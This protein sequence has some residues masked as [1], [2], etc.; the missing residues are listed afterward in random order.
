MNIRDLPRGCA[1]PLNTT[2][3]IKVTS[4]VPKND[5]GLNERGNSSGRPRIDDL[6]DS[7]F[8]SEAQISILLDEKKL[9]AL[10][11][12]LR[13]A[14]MT[15][16][17]WRIT[18]IFLPDIHGGL[19]MIKNVKGMENRNFYLDQISIPLGYIA[20]LYEAGKLSNLP[21]EKAGDLRQFLREIKAALPYVEDYARRHGQSK[22]ADTISASAVALASSIS[23]DLAKLEPFFLKE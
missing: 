18:K 15:D 6:K 17:K 12:A 22:G 2:S 23:S 16:S 20:E 8:A 5:G 9:T 19:Q 1:K 11:E 14:G 21:I 3:L 4:P 13:K 7:R 10:A